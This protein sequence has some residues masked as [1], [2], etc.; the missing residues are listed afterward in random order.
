MSFSSMTLSREWSA[1]LPLHDYYCGGCQTVKVDVYRSV[2]EGAVA[3]P[4]QC[5]GRAMSWVPNV[6]R[7][8]ASN[9]PTFKEFD[10]F[11]GRN[12]KVHVSSLKQLRAIEKQSEIDH[13]NGEGQ[14]LVFRAFSQSRSQMD[15]SALHPSFNGGEAPTK[16]AAHRFG[17]SLVKSSEEIPGDYGPGVTDDNASALP[18]D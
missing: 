5:C 17:S 16:A 3:A 2:E 9:G 18:S 10:T 8:D 7:M 15:Q 12:E 4:P 14:P 6:G 13:K 11:N 1:S